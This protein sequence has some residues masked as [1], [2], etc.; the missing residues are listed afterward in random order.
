MS[1]KIC[2]SIYNDIFLNI[3]MLCIHIWCFTSP[4]LCF[5][6]INRMVNKL[7]WCGTFLNVKKLHAMQKKRVKNKS[8]YFFEKTNFTLTCSNVKCNIGSTHTK[9]QSY[10]IYAEILFF[11]QAIQFNWGSKRLIWLGLSWKIVMN[12][13]SIWHTL[14]VLVCVL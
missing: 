12:R 1:V 13:I 4:H 10:Q 6:K 14:D 9:N 8:I 3:C 7:K 2:Q 11:G 5:R